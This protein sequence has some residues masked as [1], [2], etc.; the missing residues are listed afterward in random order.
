MTCLVTL[1]D[2]KLQVFKNSP[3]LNTVVQMARLSFQQIK[4]RLSLV[5]LE[6]NVVGKWKSQ[7]ADSLKETLAFS[8]FPSLNP[9]PFGCLLCTQSDFVHLRQNPTQK[10]LHFTKEEK[11]EWDWGSNF[12]QGLW[13]IVWLWKERVFDRQAINRSNLWM[14][15]WKSIFGAVWSRIPAENPALVGW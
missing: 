11:S 13:I 3:K 5:H 10:V 2:R 8:N 9:P 12:D 1:F 6:K 4:I 14:G 7:N 15:S